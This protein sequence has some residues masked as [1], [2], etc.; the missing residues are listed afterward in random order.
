MIET[1]QAI[2]N[3]LCIKTNQEFK[4][5]GLDNLTFYFDDNMI[6][7]YIF[8]DLRNNLEVPLHNRNFQKSNDYYNISKILSGNKIKIVENNVNI[9]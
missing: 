2:L 5:K 8:D 3:I 6:L 7:Y 4:V 9:L 1:K